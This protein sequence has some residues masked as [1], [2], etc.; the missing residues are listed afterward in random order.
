M[1]QRDDGIFTSQDKYVKELL[2]KFKLE[3]SSS[4]KTP[5]ATATKLD[6]DPKGK[7]IDSS[8]F[9]GMIGS[10]LYLTV[11]RL[12]IMF[13]TC[14]CA[15][16]Q[17]DPRESH[18]MAA[19]RIFRYI[20]RTLNL[21][22][23]YSKG[24]GFELI[25]YSDSDY[26]GCRIDRKSTNGSCQFPCG[27]LVSWFCKKKHSVSQ[28]TTEAEYIAVGSCC[29]Q[30]LWMRNQLMDY[31]VVLN[32][33]PIFCDNTSAIAISENHVQ[34]SR[35]KNIDVRHHFIREHVERGTVKLIYTYGDILKWN[36]SPFRGER[37]KEIRNEFSQTR[38]G[39]HNL[40][41]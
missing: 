34:H 31:G 26:A 22:L 6:Q 23:W 9:R 24:T 2:R 8:L 36:H 30:I 38:Q 5:I 39:F 11:S 28:S 3:D 25:F 18:L 16:F 1:Y 14:L 15:R 7:R 37:K 33:I 12:D 40:I 13:A 29:A 35:T 19:K 21:G 17:D 41:K 4:A 20:K 27:R 10:L 32:A